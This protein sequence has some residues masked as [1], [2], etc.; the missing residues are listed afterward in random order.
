[1]LNGNTNPSGNLFDE[2]SVAQTPLSNN[3]TQKE[4]ELITKPETGVE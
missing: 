2:N 4:K 3:R 1:M